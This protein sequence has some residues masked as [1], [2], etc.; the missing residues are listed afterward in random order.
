MPGRVQM[1]LGAGLILSSM[2]A[3]GQQA[4]WTYYG[5]RGP[6]HWSKLDPAYAACNKGKEQSPIDIRGA[7]PEVSL[8]PIE[9]HYLSGPVTL[10]NTGHTVRVD[11]APGSYILANGVR[12]DLVEFHFHHP[13]EDAVNGKLADFSVNLLHKSASGELAVIEVRMN[14]GRTN[15]LLAALWPSLPRIAHATAKI[16]DA[17]NPM[18]LL[19]GNRSYYGF[20]G[21]L[22]VPPCTEGVHWFVM[23]QE[24]ELSGDQLQAFSTL[25][26]DNARR[27]Q[28]THGRKIGSSQ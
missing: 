7:K 21:S 5:K 6:E 3:M 14:E 16:D 28:A 4:D 24:T 25:Y 27:L 20:L 9:F 19:P 8:K 17:I 22:T 23:Q 15:G 10:L 1:L 2:A 11:V 13:A 12:Y 26:V 18:G